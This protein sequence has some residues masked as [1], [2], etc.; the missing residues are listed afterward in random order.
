MGYLVFKKQKKRRKQF[1]AFRTKTFFGT[2]ETYIKKS[3]V[4][5]IEG[6]KHSGKTRELMKIKDKALDVYGVEPIYIDAVRPVSDW[7]YSA[8]IENGKTLEKEQE[9][10]NRVSD[11]VLI[12]DNIDSITT[13]NKKQQIIINAIDRAK[14]IVVSAESLN[15]CYYSI[16]EKLKK[17][18]KIEEVYLSGGEAVDITF[19]LFAVM[20]FFI[21]LVAGHYEMLALIFGMRYLLRG[22]N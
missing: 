12:I 1:L 4:L 18:G 2:K 22:Q 17:K 3:S 15:R 8:G 11:K 5:V 14:Y 6:V 13:K 7:F 19:Y 9:F 16:I 21:I 20:I 10:L